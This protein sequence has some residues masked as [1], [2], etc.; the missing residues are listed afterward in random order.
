MFFELKNI[1]AVKQANIELGKLTII[2][3]KNNT[4]K[5][6]ITY[7]IYGF[8]RHLFALS[9]D[10]NNFKSLT[11]E[12]LNELSSQF[13]ANLAEIFSANADE[14]IGAEFH[15][16]LEKPRVESFRSK[17]DNP[18]AGEVPLENFPRPFI[19][20]S[21]RTSIQLFQKE[22]DGNRSD[23]VKALTKSRN[24]ELLEKQVA[25]FALPIETEIDFA[26]ETTLVIKS[27]SFLKQQQP[28]LTT[29]IEDMLGVQYEIINGQILVRDKTTQKVL[30]HYR[31][32][33]SVRTLFDL[34]LW[35]KHQAQP[36]DILFMDE[37]EI[38]LHPEN[39][40]KMVR[41]LV[42]LVNNGINVFITTHSTYIIKEFNNL[43]ML[44][45]DFPEKSALMNEFG[46]TQDEVLH[47][48]DLKAYIARA[49]GTLSRVDLDEYGMIQT[50]FDDVIVQINETSN[51]LISAIDDL[52]GIV[53]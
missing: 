20:S 26:R 4:G 14:F 6:Y 34:H 35:L 2:C 12:Q 28:T 17:N 40:L 22:L 46:Y 11:Q 45:N 13:T 27:N 7:S 18:N 1:G 44:A 16:A 31:S 21:E 39:Q 37:P 36:G 19:L 38:N 43:S 8:L 48:E 53:E 23:L 52:L 33:A 9:F 24:L 42:R 49:E 29:Y 3:G 51:K 25:R 50:G 15:L 5:T 30:P 10:K 47:Q 32:S 41:L